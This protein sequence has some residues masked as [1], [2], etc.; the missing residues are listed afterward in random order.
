MVD[1][2]TTNSNFVFEEP[3]ADFGSKNRAGK[4]IRKGTTR[5]TP[6]EPEYTTMVSIA[7]VAIMPS[8]HFR[9]LLADMI[10]GSNAKK[11]RR[12]AMRAIR[13]A[14]PAIIEVVLPAPK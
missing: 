13:F 9:V 2:T 14:P 7:K 3:T 4:K 10:S 5:I 1:T 11:K 8:N 12:G 6:L